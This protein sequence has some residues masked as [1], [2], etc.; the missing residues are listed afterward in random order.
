VI[1]FNV[2]S[3]TPESMRTIASFGGGGVL[4]DFGD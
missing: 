3:L 4:F 1:L 2:G